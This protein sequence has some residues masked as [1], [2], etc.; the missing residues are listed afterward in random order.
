M[1]DLGRVLALR[2]RISLGLDVGLL[3][4]FDTLFP[5]QGHGDSHDRGLVDRVQ[6]GSLSRLSAV[7]ERLHPLASKS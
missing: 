6:G 7:D 3:S 2:L 5:D 4:R 1:A